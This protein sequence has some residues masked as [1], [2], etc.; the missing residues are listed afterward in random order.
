MSEHKLT[1]RELYDWIDSEG[2]VESLIRHGV[3]SGTEFEDA[4]TSAMWHDAVE[5]F[6]PFEDASDNLMEHLEASMGPEPAED[7]CE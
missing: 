2:G 4:M 3:E 5:M 7:D 6:E 1:N